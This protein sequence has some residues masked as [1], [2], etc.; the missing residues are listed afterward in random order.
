MLSLNIF[1]N[2]VFI[3]QHIWRSKRQRRYNLEVWTHW[4]DFRISEETC[5][6]NATLNVGQFMVHRQSCCRWVIL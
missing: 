2:F 5:F 4:N 3:K 1:S 6:T